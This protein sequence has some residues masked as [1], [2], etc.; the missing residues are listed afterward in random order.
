ML[1][2]NYTKEPLKFHKISRDDIHDFY[3][4]N[5]LFYLF[6]SAA[7]ESKWTDIQMG[8]KIYLISSISTAS[9]LFKCLIYMYSN[10]YHETSAFMIVSFQ[11]NIVILVIFLAR[12]S[13]PVS[14]HFYLCY[15]Q[16]NVLRLN[17]YKNAL[18]YWCSYVIYL[19][20]LKQKR[21]SYADVS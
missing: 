17:L 10:Y 3:S 6:P 20:E 9:R 2:R 14:S 16:E 13:T 15:Q 1:V 8:P 5:A 12:C 19:L 11:E 21:S 18:S 7:W 4:Q